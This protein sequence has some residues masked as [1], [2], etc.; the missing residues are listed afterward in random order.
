MIRALRHGVL[1]VVALGAAMVGAC[2][3]SEPAPAQGEA[4]IQGGKR[5][6]GYPAVGVVRL[7]MA[8]SFCSATLI[9]PDVVLTA[10]HCIEEPGEKIDAFF[11]GDGKAVPDAATDPAEL[12][13]VAHEVVA[14]ARHPDFEY[15]EYCPGP[16]PDLALVKLKTP[17]TD[18]AP[19]KIGGAPKTK[20]ECVAVGFGAHARK[21]TDRD[22]FLEKRSA[23]VVVGEVRAATFDVLTGTGAP[24]HGDSGGA[25]FCGGLLAGATSCQPDYPPDAVSFTNLTAAT[26]WIT[27]MVARFE[28]E[29]E[30][31]RDA[32]AERD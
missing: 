16:V 12:G 29:A 30:R 6:R 19:M 22:T 13:M 11:T 26:T 8:Q 3:S 15:F 1:V 14:Q 10:G 18:I 5:E 32:G 23:K 24:A 9:A 4:E 20:D 7:A 25:V 31:A 28:T 2:R 17:I 27:S 21:G